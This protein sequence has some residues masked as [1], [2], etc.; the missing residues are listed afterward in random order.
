MKRILFSLIL[1]VFL[2]LP[3]LAA[4][5]KLGWDIPPVAWTSATTVRIYEISGENRT[6]VV[7]VLA[8]SKEATIAGVTP[9]VH[10]YVARAYSPEWQIESDDSN[11]VTTPPIPA[12]PM[13][14]KISITI[15]IP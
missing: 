6:M 9:G 14:L 10:S 13:N 2:G 3:V 15:T 12:V 11:I 7:E 4:D 8:F 1:F 5:L